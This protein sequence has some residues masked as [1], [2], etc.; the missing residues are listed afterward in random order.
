[1]KTAEFIAEQQSQSET[2]TEATDH[3]PDQAESPAARIR[4]WQWK[5]GQ[6]GNP[7]GRP[8]RDFAAM[9]ARMIIEAE[10]DEALLNEY[11]EG[12]AKQ[13]RKGNAYT[14]KELAER[15]YGKMPQ[16]VQVTNTD[17]I[18]ALLVEG[19]KRVAARKSNTIQ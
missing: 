1:M 10:G 13:L 9:F 12:F 7:G 3:A 19:R 8:K 6:S 17:S 4:K 15:G 5:K 11:A 14:F 16:H 2:G 18:S